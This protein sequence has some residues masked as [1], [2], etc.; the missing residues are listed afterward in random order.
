MRV[1]EIHCSKGGIGINTL[2]LEILTCPDVCKISF[3]TRH[4]CVS[5]REARHWAA[6]CTRLVT[7]GYLAGYPADRMAVRL[8]L[9][10]D[11]ARDEVDGMPPAPGRGAA[12][13]AG[14]LHFLCYPTP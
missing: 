2:R 5:N 3:V 12:T 7:A 4:Q 1:S 10:S 6:T 9:S 11:I 8:C 13:H 14:W